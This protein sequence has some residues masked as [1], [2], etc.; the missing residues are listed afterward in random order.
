[1]VLWCR[2][3]QGKTEEEGQ[4]VGGK[5]FTF[6]SYRLGVHGVGAD[7]DTL[8][9]APRHVDR[10]DFFSSFHDMLG[11][12]KGVKDIRVRGGGGACMGCE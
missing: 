6:G 10:D 8:L 12:E 4:K 5:I 11:S 7:I 2:P 3:A 9:V 1:M